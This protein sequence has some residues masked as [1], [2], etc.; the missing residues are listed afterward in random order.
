MGKIDSIWIQFNGHGSEE[1]IIC[2]FDENGQNPKHYPRASW[3]RNFVDEIIKYPVKVI[4]MFDCCHSANAMNMPSEYIPGT[5]W[6]GSSEET[7]GQVICLAACQ[8][9]ETVMENNIANQYGTEEL[10]GD[11][12]YDLRK[13]RKETKFQITLGEFFI[14][15]TEMSAKKTKP[16][17]PMLTGNKTFEEYNE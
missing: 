6:K 10:F 8:L 14:R 1:G 12:T 9:H 5:G 17:H 7:P 11:F 15:M 4:A 2:S 13:L 3:K 16:V